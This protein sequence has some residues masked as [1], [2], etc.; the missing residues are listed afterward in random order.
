[1]RKAEGISDW[2]IPISEFRLP[3]CYCT[4]FIHWS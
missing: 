1:M 3:N 4:G 2:V